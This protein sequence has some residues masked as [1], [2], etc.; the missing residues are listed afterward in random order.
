MQERELRE[1]IEDVRVGKLPRRH[2]IQQLVSLGLTAPMA[3]QLL[4]HSGIAQAQTTSLYKPTKRGGGGALKALWWQGATLLQ[5]HFASGTKDQ[6]GSR[7]FYEPLAVWDNE[8]NLVPILAAEIPTR[9][10]GGLA[11]D[12]KSVVWKLKKGVTWHDGKPFSADDCVFTWEFARDPATAAITAGVYKD[13]KVEKIDSHS[14]RVIFQKPT[15]FWAT[16]FVAAEGMI[17]PKHLFAAYSGA[18]SREAPNNLKPVGTGPY[19]FVDFKPG[20]IVRG[21]INH[22]YHMPNRPFF[23]SIEMKGG[24]DATSAARAVLQTGEY[25]YAWNLQVEDEVLKRMEAGGKGKVRVIDSGDIEFIQLNP[26]DPFN[27]V[28]GERAS[29]KSKHFAFSEPAVREA[30]S[31]LVDRKGVQDF[32]YG[33]TGVATS[34]FLNNPPRFRSPNTKWEFNIDKANQILEAAGWKKGS[35]GVREKGGKKM[36]LVFQTSVNS[37]RQKEQAV[38]K[39]ACQKAGIEL[40]LKS[41]TG[42]VFFSS[43][44]ANPD[45]YGKFWCDMQMYTT[46]M[47]QPDAERFMDQYT[48]REVSSKANKWL[49]RNIARYR[50]EEYDKA[51]HAAEA[52]LDPVKRAALFIRMNDMVIKDNAVIP[53][54]S[55]PRARGANLKLVASLSGWDLDFSTLQN[56]YREA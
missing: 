45:T 48:S 4:M 19:K 22:N 23:D 40:E 32:I 26:T 42:S 46:T 5:P 43:D 29:I 27:E 37:I 13:V 30:M 35:D 14:V 36:R 15:P 2:F 44:V 17:I 47:T 20:D 7:I 41:V 24:G 1:L 3:A 10:N 51:Y 38:I 25:D 18:K 54:I 39:Q 16:T 56:W 12:G 21:E 53:L 49:G 8:G 50:N 28:E 31:L 55:R 52:E 33:R 34:N 9:E 6:E 11:A